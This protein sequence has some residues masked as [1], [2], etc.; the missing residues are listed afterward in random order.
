MVENHL[1]SL[2]FQH[3]E[4]SEQHLIKIIDVPTTVAPIFTPAFWVAGFARN[5]VKW[6]IFDGFQPLCV[7]PYVP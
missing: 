6:D 2:I 3:C 5:V 4:R 7:P 1:K